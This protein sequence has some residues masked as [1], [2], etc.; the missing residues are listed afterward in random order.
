M[1][2][3]IIKFSATCFLIIIISVFAFQS[4]SAQT[5]S[6]ADQLRE[7]A[8]NLQTGRFDEAE[9]ILRR[10]IKTSPANIDAH[11]LL[12][13]IL[14]QN[15]NTKEAEREYRLAL[16]SNPNAVSPL[17]NLAVLLAKTKR[18]P[19][20]IKTFEK[21]LQ[22][23][24]NHPQ[25]I[26]NLGFLYNSTGKYDNA[27]LFLE[28]ANQI[29]P[30]DYEI[31]FNLGTA[32]YNLKKF[33]E[34][35][36]VLTSANLIS[37]DSVEPI[38]F[39]GVIAFDQ[40]DL[41]LAARYF[42][43]A[44]TLRPDYADVNFMIGEVLAKQKRYAD[45]VKFYE[46]AVALDKTK[47]V[48]FVR[49]GGT[50]LINYEAP[51][52]FQY[53]KEAV[54]L[55]PDIAEIKYFFAIAARSLGEYDLALGEAKKAIALKETA[56]TNALIGSM[57]VDRDNYT[58]AEKY[59]RK[60]VSLNKNHFNSQNDLGRLLIKQQKFTEGLIF[61]QSAASLIP[62]NADVHYQLFL[63]YTRL[64]RKVEADKEFALF[65]KLSNKK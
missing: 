64:K 29:Q 32:F 59:L 56:D 16:K 33:E 17:A 10:V 18:E 49:L 3:R 36:K 21:V 28:K 26:T 4:V 6:I 43:N 46:K 65:K 20:A 30:D 34:A 53:F 23:K 14:D 13:I 38:Y 50:Y 54:E 41:E 48:Y 1:N 60:A 5:N 57:L 15:G 7:A 47:S 42:E 31:K 24:P 61:L 35:K 62:D 55:F 44:L 8:A 12:G 9:T 39:L 63:T 22:L 51:K 27:I 52:A 45:A 19:E 40:S 2:E 58:E 37:P 11:N 25:A